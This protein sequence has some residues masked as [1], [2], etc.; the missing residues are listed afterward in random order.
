M[1]KYECVR[2]RF[3]L[4]LQEEGEEHRAVLNEYAKKG[5]RYVGYIPRQM[6]LYGRIRAVDLIF[7]MDV[8]DA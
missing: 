3:P 4:G 2:V 7:E 8:E 6:K 5:Y 1:K